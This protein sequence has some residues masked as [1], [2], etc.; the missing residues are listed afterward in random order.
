MR[1]LIGII[2][3]LLALA[4]SGSVHGIQLPESSYDFYVYDETGTISESLK[5]EIVEIN[6]AIDEKSGAQIVVAVVE[7]VEGSSGAQEYANKLFEKWKIGDS[8]KDNG[9]L[10]LV[11][12]EERELWIEIGYGLEGALPDGKVGGIRD[13]YVIPY[14]KSGDYNEGIRQ[15]FYALVEEVSKEYNI[16]DI[17]VESPKATEES[18]STSSGIGEIIIVVGIVALVI[19]DMIFF[20]GTITMI[21]IRIFLGGRGPGGFGGGSG[22]GSSRGSGGGGSSGGGGAGG[23]W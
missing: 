2:T 23:S 3:L 8:E 6:K 12:M 10:F 9:V 18:A 20:R 16:E 5:N 15:G 1:K 17:G 14:F 21:I 4:F 13:N 7:N 11:S 22:G 19:L